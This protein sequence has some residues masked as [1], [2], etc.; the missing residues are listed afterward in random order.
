M[1]TLSVTVAVVALFT[2]ASGSAPAAPPRNYVDL[3]L[4]LAVDVSRSM[5]DN[6]QRVQRDGYVAAFRSDELHRA[7][8]SVPYGRIAVT[9]VE[10]SGQAYQHVLIPWR[11]ISSDEDALVFADDLARAPLAVDSSTSIA[12][13]LKFAANAFRT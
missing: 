9:Y 5:D 12:G 11:I 8:A 10:W 4:I 13:A 6:E 1:R 2:A 7:I 3:Q